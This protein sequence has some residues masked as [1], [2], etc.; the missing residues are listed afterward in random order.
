VSPDGQTCEYALHTRRNTITLPDGYRWG[1]DSHGLRAYVI[2]SP[3]DD[4]HPDAKNLISM[5]SSKI[6][7]VIQQNRQRRLNTE[8]QQRAEEADMQGVWVGLSDSIR[9]GNCQAGS[10]RWATDHGLDPKRHYPAL[11]ICRI[12][13]GDGSAGRV[14]VAISAAIIRHKRDMERGYCETGIP[15]K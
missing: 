15:A 9:A 4:Y 13:A 7:A 14:R 3:A 6:V 10:I 8:A 5:T 2:A 1:E 11:E 12:G